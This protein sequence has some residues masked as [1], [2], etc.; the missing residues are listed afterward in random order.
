MALEVR[1]RRRTPLN[2]GLTVL[3]CLML[4]VAMTERLDAASP[5]RSIMPQLEEEFGLSELQVKGALGALLEFAHDHLTK[6]EFDD[7]AARI[8]NA[9]RI[10]QQVKLSGVVNGP[11]DT[12]DEYEKSLVRL[13]MSQAMAEEFG[14][15]VVKYL[16]AAG[17]QHERDILARVLD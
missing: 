4:C 3:A 14:P 17:Y 7:L 1:M 5:G 15:A 8:P 6:V 10:R 16:G 2:L 13:G 12:I 11:L 9:D